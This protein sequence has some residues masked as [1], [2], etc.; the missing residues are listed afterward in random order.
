MPGAGGAPEIATHARDLLLILPQSKRTFVNKLD[1]VTSI[2]FGEGGD[3]R[4]TLGMPGGGPLAVVTD[5]GVLRPDPV[6]RELVLVE[7]VPGV[8]VD[9]VV[10]ATG[11]PLRVAEDVGPMAPPA[12]AEL[13]ALR[14]LERASR[15][16]H[17]HDD[18][19]AA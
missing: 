4:K 15:A 19:G 14:R 13:L 12:A 18:G 8:T 5:L 3:S 7:L 17:G 2:G 1:F 9:Q 10:G 16:K 11:W 6:T